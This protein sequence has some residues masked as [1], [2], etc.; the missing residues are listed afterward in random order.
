MESKRARDFTTGSMP[1][2][3]LAFAMPMFIGNLLQ[4]AYNTVDSIWVG[5]Y[6]GPQAL[7]AVS[8]G[9]P[10]IFALIALI[11][12]LT[13]ATTTLVSQYYGAR[14]HDKVHAT[15]ANSLTL[16]SILGLG[17]AGLGYIIRW[18]LLRLLNAPPDIIE[19]AAVY[20]G[21]YM[22]G[23]LPTFIY[24]VSSSILRGLGDSQ[25][26]MTFLAAATIMN[27]ILDP[28]MIFGIGPFP[29]MGVAG[30]AWATVISQAFSALLAIMH[31][32]RKMHVADSLRGLLR[33]D[34][35]LTW[36]TM[37]IGLPA[38]AQQTV[39]SMGMMVVNSILNR[40]GSVA[41]AGAGA[42]SRIEQFAFMPAMS[43]GLAVSALVGQN[44]GAGR[45]DRVEQA[46]KWGSIL[47]MS[48]TAVVAAVALLI[49]R[50]LLASFA[51][52]AAVLAA[53]SAYLRWSALAFIPL[54]AMFVVAGVLRGAGDTLPTFFITLASLW[55]IRIPLVTVLSRT[56]LGAEG[57]W[58]GMAVGPYVGLLLTYLYYRTGKWKGK[59]VARRAVPSDIG[60]DGDPDIE[61]GIPLGEDEQLVP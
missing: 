27:I 6:L 59:A 14:L 54:A 20:L 44:L 56:S 21:I 1:R 40:F 33:L 12:G 32:I 16:L 50:V 13:L 3:L 47:A 45:E 9:F 42:G 57:V 22:L 8:V 43:V 24:S 46:V 37:K 29:K 34:W 58:A 36:L 5:R 38:G 41:V 60:L 31:L 53:G 49:P 51:K 25:T 28:I 4:A 18:P 17:L 2:H 61:T 26:P 7:A 15:V 52:D 30:A 23:L 11:T 19:T 35:D 48:I 55:L 39:M 10:V